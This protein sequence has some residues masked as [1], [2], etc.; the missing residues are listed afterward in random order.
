MECEYWG[1][2]I[3]LEEQDLDLDLEEQKLEYKIYIKEE[4]L[5]DDTKLDKSMLYIIM[6][7][8]LLS[9]VLILI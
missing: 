5:T 6:S 8:S 9:C 4:N 1:Q 7:M 2:F 3:D